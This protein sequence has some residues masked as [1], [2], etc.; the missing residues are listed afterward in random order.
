MLSFSYCIFYGLS[1][2]R[3]QSSVDGPYRGKRGQRWKCRRWTKNVVG[4][5]WKT[6]VAHAKNIRACPVVWTGDAPTRSNAAAPRIF[7]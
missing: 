3:K 5:D 1:T 4:R 6:R 7:G 2:F